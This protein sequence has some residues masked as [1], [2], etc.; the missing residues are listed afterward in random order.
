MDH[1]ARLMRDMRSYFPREQGEW[2][3]GDLGYVGCEGFLYGCKHPAHQVQAAWDIDTEFLTNLVAFY[4]ARVENVISQVK[5]HA[6]AQAP[7]RGGFEAMAMYYEISLTLTALELKHQF[8]TTN[9]TRF[10]V[11]GPWAHS[12]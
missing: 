1:D 10:E 3:M 8:L 11:V 2:H 7:F 9:L 12:F 5:A 6:W 4:R